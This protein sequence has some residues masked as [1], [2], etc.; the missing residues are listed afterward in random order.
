MEQAFGS[1]ALD[2]ESL[3]VRPCSEPLLQLGVRRF[4]V[5]FVLGF[6]GVSVPPHHLRRT[7]AAILTLHVETQN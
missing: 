5:I 1:I 4:I 7:R 2:L 3:V 6:P